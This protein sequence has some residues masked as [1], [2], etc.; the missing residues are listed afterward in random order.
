MIFNHQIICWFLTEAAA[1]RCGCVSVIKNILRLVCCWS[2]YTS[3]E[4]IIFMLLLASDIETIAIYFTTQNSSSANDL[5]GCK[6]LQFQSTIFV[7]LCFHSNSHSR[8]LF[9]F[10]SQFSFPRHICKWL[11]WVFYAMRF[12]DEYYTDCYPVIFAHHFQQWTMIIHSH[13]PNK[14]SECVFVCV[15]ACL[16]LYKR[17]CIE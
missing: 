2:N 11:D 1:N 3:T 14:S 6:H 10:L 13:S 7:S 15:R 4:L 16:C 17:G 8:S 5:T 9:L 12:V